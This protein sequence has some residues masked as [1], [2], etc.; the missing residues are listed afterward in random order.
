MVI[1]AVVNGKLWTGG[2]HLKSLLELKL[3]DVDLG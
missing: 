3:A 1:D 2:I